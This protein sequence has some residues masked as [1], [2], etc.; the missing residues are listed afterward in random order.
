MLRSIFWNTA[1]TFSW[2]L[3]QPI[4]QRT[5]LW[6]GSLCSITTGIQCAQFPKSM[7]TIL[8][9][10]QPP[11]KLCFPPHTLQNSTLSSRNWKKLHSSIEILLRCKIYDH[12][13]MIKS[14]V[15]NYGCLDILCQGWIRN[16]QIICTYRGKIRCNVDEKMWS[17]EGDNID[18][19]SA[20]FVGQL[21]T[22][23]AYGQ[24]IIRHV[25]EKLLFQQIILWG[26]LSNKWKKRKSV[27]HMYRISYHNTQ[28]RNHTMILP[29]VSF[30]RNHKSQCVIL[31]KPCLLTSVTLQDKSQNTTTPPICI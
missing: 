1:F 3:M 25:R 29:P 5:K 8:T 28:R 31:L 26:S 7:N 12:I 10:N 18:K 19:N 4:Q 6:I 14:D 15:I 13:Q 16:G 11:A 2:Q 30:H 23:R 24:H 17:N 21:L 20:L 22:C 9:Q 27:A